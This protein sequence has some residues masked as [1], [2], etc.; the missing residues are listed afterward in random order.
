[1]AI[2]FSIQVEIE[3]DTISSISDITEQIDTLCPFCKR[4][5]ALKSCKSIAV[6]AYEIS[7]VVSKLSRHFPG[8]TL[9]GWK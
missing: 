4:A 9:S 2:K 5:Q 7:P 6:Q 1:M 3:T 8:F